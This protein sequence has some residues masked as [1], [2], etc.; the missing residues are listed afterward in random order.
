MLQFLGRISYQA[1]VRRK[2]CLYSVLACEGVHD[3]MLLSMPSMTWHGPW[4]E[5]RHHPRSRTIPCTSM[6]RRR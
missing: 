4:P 5:L 6:S 2:A 3:D 1:A